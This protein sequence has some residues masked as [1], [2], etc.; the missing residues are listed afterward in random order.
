MSA[1]S[2]QPRFPGAGE[3]PLN[4]SPLFRPSLPSK[5]PRN[6]HSSLIPHWAGEGTSGP[7][8]GLGARPPSLLPFSRILGLQCFVLTKRS[9]PP[10]PATPRHSPPSAPT[11]LCE[12]NT[13]PQEGPKF[14]HLHRVIRMTW[15][16][17]SFL[18]QNSI[19]NST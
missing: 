5:P 1:R 17:P 14:D 16:E 19:R 9:F 15:K 4:I 8:S 10:L 6:T 3:A 12:A 13:R 11:W 2:G 7:R 18:Q